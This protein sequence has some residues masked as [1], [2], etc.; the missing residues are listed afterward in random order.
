MEIREPYKAC[1]HE[2]TVAMPA[3]GDNF[4]VYCC[5]CEV[6]VDLVARKDLFKKKDS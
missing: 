2:N 5:D 4:A 3:E 1:S 6:L